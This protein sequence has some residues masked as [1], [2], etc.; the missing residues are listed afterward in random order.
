[1]GEYNSFHQREK[2]AESWWQTGHS[3]GETAQLKQKSSA[4]VHFDKQQ[5]FPL[6]SS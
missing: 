1:M 4:E 2:L 6:Y 3:Y 5:V